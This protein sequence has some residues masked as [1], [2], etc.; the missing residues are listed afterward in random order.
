MAGFGLVLRNMTQPISQE[1]FRAVFGSLSRFRR[2]VAADSFLAWLAT[3]AHRR[4]CDHLR[5]RPPSRLP[6]TQAQAMLQELPERPL[7]TGLSEDVNS[8]ADLIRRAL[9]PRPPRKPSR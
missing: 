3:I 6:G 5:K 7:E 8:H 2:P 1:V 4:A 9:E